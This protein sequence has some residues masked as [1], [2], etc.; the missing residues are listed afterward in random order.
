MS[1]DTLTIGPGSTAT[2]ATL[3][4]TKG[5]GKGGAGRPLDAGGADER[6][7]FQVAAEQRAGEVNEHE[8]MTLNRAIAILVAAHTK[9]GSSS[10][11]IEITHAAPS[12]G[13][14]YAA[15]W[16]ILAH[17]NKVREEGRQTDTDALAGE[18]LWWRT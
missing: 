3:I 15:A 9:P 11:D 18:A 14:D 1:N 8:M 4:V 17:W 2:S 12:Q 10:A 5:G 7:H 16:R 13:D 6:A